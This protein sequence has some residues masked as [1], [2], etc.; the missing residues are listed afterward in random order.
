MKKLMVAA[1]AALTATIGFG[2]ESSNIVGYTTAE[3]TK[4]NYNTMTVQ[5]G[6]VGTGMFSLND[7]KTEGM[8]AAVE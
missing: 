7:I 4:G 6:G 5:L 3:L 8:T 2:V 1:A